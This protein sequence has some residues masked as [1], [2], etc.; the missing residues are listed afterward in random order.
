MATVILAIAAAGIL[1]PFAG[2]ASVQYEAERKAVA[3]NLASELTEIILMEDF[4]DIITTY[5]GYSE[6]EG[7]LLDA[8]GNPHTGSA[9]EGFSRSVSCQSATVASVDLV[10]ITVVVSYNNREIC[11]VT[12]LAGD[13]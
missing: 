6:A 2:A 13:H 5:H 8:A 4:T 10:A 3:A 11:R 9:Y 12:T 7:A 1:L